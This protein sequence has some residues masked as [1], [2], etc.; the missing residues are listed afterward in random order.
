MAVSKFDLAVMVV[1]AALLLRI[2]H[3]HRIVI[4]A[5]TPAEAAPA[6][7]PAAVCPATDD[8]PFSADCI[9]F[10]EGGA[11]PD[12]HRRPSA[13]PVSADAGAALPATACPP[14][15]ENA[16]YSANC[17]KFLSGWYWQADP[18][19]DAH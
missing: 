1:M 6:P 10:I 3:D 9:K 2:E 16:P 11:L 5:P 7:Q 4:A 19:A 13:P 14:S 12:N 8:V 15:N 18:A 17:I